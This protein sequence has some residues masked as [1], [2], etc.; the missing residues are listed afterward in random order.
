MD[1]I[2]I[3]NNPLVYK[4][5]IERDVVL[6]TDYKAVLITTRDYIHQGAKLLSHP[7]AGS[8]KP[9]ETPYRTVL[10]SKVKVALDF[11]S[12]H[13][14]ETA[15]ERFIS[16]S[17]SMGL[18]SYNNICLDDFQIIDESLIASALASLSK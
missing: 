3:T 1:Y 10:V 5:Y 16:L 9:Y 6:V 12:L 7:Q 2:I 18:K 17:A 8:I 13:Y 15:L 14:I 4:K 11:D